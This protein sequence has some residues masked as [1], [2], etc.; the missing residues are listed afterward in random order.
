[1][2]ATR[3]D[4]NVTRFLRALCASAAILAA[5]LVVWAVAFSPDFPILPQ[6]EGAAWIAAPD[7]V[8]TGAVT[9]STRAPRRVR[10]VRT[11]DLEASQVPGGIEV[12]AL[13]NFRLSINGT[14]VA[15][16]LG[17]AGDDHGADSGTAAASNW[18]RA[19]RI[20]SPP[21]V[22]GRNRIEVE[23]WNPSGPPLLR[24]GSLRNERGFESDERWQVT[25]G[26]APLRL[27][28]LADDTLPAVAT[29]AATPA[30][31]E[32]ANHRGMLLAAAAFGVV[33]AGALA[34]PGRSRSRSRGGSHGERG[35]SALI[36]GLGI[37]AFWVF[38]FVARFREL[39]LYAGFDGPHH[40]EYIRFL[41]TEGRLP[42][43][44][45]GPAMYHPPLYHALGALLRFFSGEHPG[46]P[47]RLLSFVSGGVQIF[48]A[49]GLARRLFPEDATQKT[50]TIAVAGLLPL[51]LYMSAYLSNEPLHAALSAVVCLIAVD[52]LLLPGW[53]LRRLLALGIALG[54][55]LLTKVTALLL[56][57]LLGLFLLAKALFG[58]AAPVR[59]WAARGG[60]LLAPVLVIA[61]GFYLRNWI[62][63][64]R[65]FVGNWDLPGATIGWWQFPGFHTGEYF[66][67]FGEALRR[68]FFAGFHSLA[69]G[70]YAT[71]WSDSLVGGVS[72]I[73][74]RH[75]Q[76]NWGWMTVLPALAFPATC[77][78]ALGT[79][80]LARRCFAE[81]ATPRRLAFGFLVATVA[82]YLFAVV[83][84]NLRL[85]FYAQ[86]KSAYL[87]AVAAPL[88]LALARGFVVADRRLDQPGLRW[89]RWLLHG[90]GAA[91]VAA[92]VLAFA[93]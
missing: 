73:V 50:L 4:Q 37:A 63:L 64:G 49:H 57:P 53:P 32:L 9:T 20:D 52:L 8:I 44:T 61:A 88:S 16:R 12:H 70:L 78:M 31:D 84:I 47:I 30:W 74:H 33:A 15:Q 92:I 46:T 45:D 26:A 51:N 86:T 91:F 7:R 69:D 59:S 60:T 29:L 71:L 56:G 36:V 76:W 2:N 5:G 83:F 13:R 54:L 18:K 35:S 81:V 22:P 23:V 6:S 85:P 48:V 19:T 67:S 43:A 82:T 80:S 21:F 34:R 3:P 1:M 72:A 10:F 55:A 41:A 58:E 93:G 75:A 17:P 28:R 66:F 79:A 87:L 90:W 42:L 62:E 65:P 24:L 89:M 11:V 14:P 39:P 68:P 38:L 27:V 25:E 77:A 40:L